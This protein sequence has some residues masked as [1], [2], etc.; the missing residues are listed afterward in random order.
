VNIDGT[1]NLYDAGNGVSDACKLLF[2][3][4]HPESRTTMEYRNPD[5]S[6]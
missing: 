5:L 3:M 6:V 4:G 2:V 1:Q